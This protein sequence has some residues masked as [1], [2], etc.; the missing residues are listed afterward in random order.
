M[1]I[2]FNLKDNQQ[3]DYNFSNSWY[4]VTQIQTFH[5]ISYYYIFLCNDHELLINNAELLQLLI[6]IENNSNNILNFQLYD[7]Q[8]KL[9]FDSINLS[10]KYESIKIR[11]IQPSKFQ[12]NFKQ[13]LTVCIK[14]VNNYK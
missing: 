7:E 5:N 12:S 10:A 3:I 9:V 8:N 4:Y 13:G 6:D 2:K 14:F 11:Y 1:L